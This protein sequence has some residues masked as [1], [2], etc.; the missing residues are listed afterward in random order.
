MNSD[1]EECHGI[2]RLYYFGVNKEK[3]KPLFCFDV[4]SM[5]TRYKFLIFMSYLY[6]IES[7]G[8]SDTRQILV[9]I[10]VTLIFLLSYNCF[11]IFVGGTGK[12]KPVQ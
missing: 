8:T 1:S 5:C 10:T 7:S 12:K 2:I 6:C 3:L 4:V 11:F 9:L